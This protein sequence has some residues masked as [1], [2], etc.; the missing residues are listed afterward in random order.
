M[1]LT[2]AP[3]TRLGPHATPMAPWG[4]FTGKT[5][6]GGEGAPVMAARLSDPRASRLADPGAARYHDP[7][8]ARIHP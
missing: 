4:A 8:A 7:R 1:P 5:V 6:V 3:R 2:T